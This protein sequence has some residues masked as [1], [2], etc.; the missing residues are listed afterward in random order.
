MSS[1]RLTLLACNGFHRRPMY[2]D[3]GDTVARLA[4]PVLHRSGVD[5]VQLMVDGD[6]PPVAG[7]CVSSARL[8]SWLRMFLR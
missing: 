5:A 1:E 7:P 3:S 6:Q 2:V 4:A 8:T